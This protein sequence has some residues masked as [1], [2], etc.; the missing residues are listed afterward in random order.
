M[1]KK[2]KI[3]GNT[4]F[5]GNISGEELVGKTTLEEFVISVKS[6]FRILERK[7]LLIETKS[8]NS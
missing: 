5:I 1:K 8:L 7:I 3:M 6:S 2:F 4:F